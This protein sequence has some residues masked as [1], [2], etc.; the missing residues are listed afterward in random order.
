MRK[1][2][3]ILDESLLSLCHV[4]PRFWTQAVKFSVKP[5]HPPSH[6]IN[7]QHPCSL[8]AHCLC[9]KLRVRVSG[10]GIFLPISCIFCVYFVF[11]FNDAL[12]KA[13][14][15]KPDKRKIIKK[16]CVSCECLGGRAQTFFPLN[17]DSGSWMNCIQVLALL[18]HQHRS[19]SFTQ[20]SPGLLGT[21]MQPVTITTPR[22]WFLL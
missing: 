21:N 7:P 15:G 1:S 8:F 18:W 5:I 3:E 17:G 22:A 19:D 14:R 12:R 10:L 2:Q 16:I 9:I 4:G 11:V 13:L 20:G 6:P